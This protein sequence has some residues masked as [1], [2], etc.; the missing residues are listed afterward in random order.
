M[1]ILEET[2]EHLVFERKGL[3]VVIAVVLGLV[4]VAIG[5]GIANAWLDIDVAL[6]HKWVW[7]FPLAVLVLGLLLIYQGLWP[8]SFTV[9]LRTHK[10]TAKHYF[11]WHLLP[12]VFRYE[13]S[14]IQGISTTSYSKDLATGPA[15]TRNVR[16]YQ[17]ILDLSDA[18]KREVFTSEDQDNVKMIVDALMRITGK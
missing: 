5:V 13:L 15:S 10:L 6:D 16:F 9:D 2:S 12:S 4:L 1:R 8:T 3:D 11:K 14:D 17:I 18:K 7:S